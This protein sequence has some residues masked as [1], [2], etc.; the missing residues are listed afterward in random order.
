MAGSYVFGAVADATSIPTVM[1]LCA[2]I[3]VCGIYITHRCI[4]DDQHSKRD[5]AEALIKSHDSTATV[6]S[7]IYSD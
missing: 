3:S 4:Q 2:G 1:L 7:S 6:G 5:S